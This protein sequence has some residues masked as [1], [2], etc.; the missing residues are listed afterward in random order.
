MAPL[1]CE[2]TLALVR[3]TREASQ[4]A[5]F[6]FNVS[7]NLVTPRAINAVVG[8]VY[9]REDPAE[10]ARAQV[11]HDELLEAYLEHGYVPY[12]ASITDMT[13]LTTPDT[14]WDVCRSLKQALDPNGILAPGRYNLRDED[15]EH[16]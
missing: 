16:S 11:C 12:R 3:L 7:L 14:F 4:R 6:E 13:R 10:T 5:G 1:T 2:D 9:D 8:I 15:P